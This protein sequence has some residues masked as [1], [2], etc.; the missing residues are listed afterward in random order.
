M[1]LESS[2]ILQ[3]PSKA[4]VSKG[5]SPRSGSTKES[6]GSKRTFTCMKGG[7]DDCEAMIPK[8]VVAMS[9]Q[10]PQTEASTPAMSRVTQLPKSKIETLKPANALSIAS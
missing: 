4:I 1:L 7:L 2:G 8:S 5:F 6:V 3:L 9:P 10:T